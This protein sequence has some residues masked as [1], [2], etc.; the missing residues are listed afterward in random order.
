MWFR[1][2]YFTDMWWKSEHGP[3]LLGMSLYHKFNTFHGVNVH[4]IRRVCNE[5]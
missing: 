4:R 2:Y 3:G 1:V 5:R